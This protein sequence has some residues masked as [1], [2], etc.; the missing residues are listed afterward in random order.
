MNSEKIKNAFPIGC[1]V[2][3][4]DNSGACHLLP[5]GSRG[6]VIG[7]YITSVF[8]EECLLRVKWNLDAYGESLYFPFRFCRSSE[9]AS[10]QTKILGAAS[11]KAGNT[12][13]DAT[14]C[15]KCGS[16]LKDPGM[17]PIYKHCPICEP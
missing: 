2:E 12:Q 17:G 15:V 10:V 14:I 8:D 13:P 5:I 4:I 3:L 1:E 16:Q 6:N 7:Y 11:L 9:I